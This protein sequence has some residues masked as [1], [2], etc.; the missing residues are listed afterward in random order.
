[1]IECEHK[2]VLERKIQTHTDLISRHIKE[3]DGKNH[4]ELLRLDKN[5]TI[6]KLIELIKTLRESM[7]S[8]YSIELELSKELTKQKELEYNQ[9]NQEYNHILELKKLEYESKKLD[10]EI[11]KLEIQQSQPIQQPIQQSQ[12]IETII[13]E[14]FNT[15]TVFSTNNSDTIKMTVFYSKFIEWIKTKYPNVGY[16]PNKLFTQ[17][18]NKLKIGIY[19]NS[20]TNLNGTSGLLNRKFIFV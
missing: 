8:K 1:M 10:L 2:D 4:K 9:K 16:P 18:F 12:I 17:K 13:I 7:K 20:I 6:D 14:F 15:C 11:R 3:F 5:F 19:K